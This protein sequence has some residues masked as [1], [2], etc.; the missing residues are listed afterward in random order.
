M[1]NKYLSKIY[2]EEPTGAFTHDGKKYNLNKYLE[3]GALKPVTMLPTSELKWVLKYDTP[4]IDRLK[5]AD[6][7][8][9]L[10]VTKWKGRYVAVDGLHRLTKAVQENVSTLPCK[11]VDLD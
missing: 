11:I 9:P 5:K 6:I 8:A 2:Q 4:D 3:I 10:L 7:S 1:T